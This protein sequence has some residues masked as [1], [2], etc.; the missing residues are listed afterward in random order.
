VPLSPRVRQQIEVEAL[1]RGYLSRQDAEVKQLRTTEQI[2]LPSDVDYDNIG[3]LSA[4]IREKLAHTRPESLGA[5][6]R[7]PGVTP[8]AILAVMSHLRQLVA[9][10]AR[11]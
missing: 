4:E 3:G 1:Y 9:A 10:P 5:M 7:I 2:L 11:G 8:P 6:G